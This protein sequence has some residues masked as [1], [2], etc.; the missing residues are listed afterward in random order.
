MIGAYVLAGELAKASGRHAD[1]FANYEKV[2]RSFI[3]LS[4]EL[5]SGLPMLLPRKRG[6]TISA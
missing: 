4:S 5:L 2:L 1:A 3:N 6:G